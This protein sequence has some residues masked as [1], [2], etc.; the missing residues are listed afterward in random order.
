MKIVNS[1]NVKYYKKE[2]D[3]KIKNKDIS[4]DSK[5]KTDETNVAADDTKVSN[6]NT[7]VRSEQ[8]LI[9]ISILKEESEKAYAHL[10]QIVEDL[11]QRQ[12]YSIEQLGKVIGEDAE[13]NQLYELNAEDIKVDQKARDEAKQMVEEGGPLSAEKVSTRIVDFAKAIS[14]G[15]KSKFELL[16]GAIED[17]F[18]AVKEIYGDEIPEITQETYDLVQEKLEAWNEE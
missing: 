18:D 8:D 9:D 3:N 10:R 11:L 1:A 13:G 16:K 6:E 15:D 7:T 5:I 17:G 2:A 12:G 4:K 14:G